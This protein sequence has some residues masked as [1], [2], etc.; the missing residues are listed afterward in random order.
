MLAALECWNAE[1]RARGE[2]HLAIGIGPNYGPAVLGDIGS[3]HS[4]SFTVIG[5]TVNTASRS[6]R[7]TRNLQTPLVVGYPVIAAANSA[8]GEIAEIVARLED[9]GEQPL[10]GRNEPVRIWARPDQS[11]EQ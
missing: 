7:L 1:R 3:E 4:F 11:V 2:P 6:Q 10:R 9:R 5:D 8:T